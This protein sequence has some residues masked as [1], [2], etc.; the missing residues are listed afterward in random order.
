LTKKERHLAQRQYDFRQRFKAGLDLAKTAATSGNLAAQQ[1]Q[2]IQES[3]NSYGNENEDNGVFVGIRNGSVGAKATT[4][5]QDDDTVSVDF[6]FNLKANQFAVTI[7]HEGRHVADAQAWVS[8]GEPTG[9]DTDLNHFYREQRAWNVSSYVG[10]GLNLKKVS[11]GSDNSGRSYKVW[12][13]GWKAAEVAT[14]RAN[15]IANILDY[16]NLKSTDTDTYSTEH[17]HRP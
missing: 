14:K 6:N 12:S 15:G 16:S 3:V 10:Q 4:L 1:Q 17:R 7:A 5:L 9:G 11:A 13:R 8:A 2:Q